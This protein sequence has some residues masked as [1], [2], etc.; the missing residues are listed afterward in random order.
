MGHLWCPPHRV[1]RPLSVASLHP[2]IPLPHPPPADVGSKSDH[3]KPLSLAQYC[4]ADSEAGFGG[5]NCDFGPNS[6]SGPH[7][8]GTKKLGFGQNLTSGLEHDFGPESDHGKTPI[9]GL[10][11]SI[12]ARP[13]V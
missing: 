7:A 2:H 13:Q 3:G 9:L 10:K 5:P 6:V 8:G 12:W 4:E 1:L 11:W